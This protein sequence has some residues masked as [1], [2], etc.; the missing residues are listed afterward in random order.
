MVIFVH[1]PRQALNMCGP[2]LVLHYFTRRISLEIVHYEECQADV[3][4]PFGLSFKATVSSVHF[5]VKRGH[6]T[7]IFRIITKMYAVSVVL[8]YSNGCT[9]EVLW[10][11][12]PSQLPPVL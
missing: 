1:I 2:L 8:E 7:R 10:W 5:Q 11:K 3:A 9:N 6:T 4:L 12:K